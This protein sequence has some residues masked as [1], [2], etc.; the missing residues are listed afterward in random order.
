MAIDPVEISKELREALLARADRLG[1]DP[2]SVRSPSPG[3]LIARQHNG[4]VLRL[5]IHAYTRSELAR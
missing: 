4:D 5:D 1:L 2:A 3:A